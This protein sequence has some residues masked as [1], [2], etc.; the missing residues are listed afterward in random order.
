VHRALG[1]HERAVNADPAHPLMRELDL[2]YPL[3]V[4]RLEAGEWSSSVP[5]RAL[6]EGRLGV[7]VGEPLDDAAAGLRAALA[8]LP[9]ELRFDGARFASG[10]TPPDHPFTRLVLESFPG[11]RPVGVPYGADMRLFCERGIPCVMAGTAGL[12]LAHAVDERVAVADLVRLA[13]GLRRV[14]EHFPPSFG[15]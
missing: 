3:S 8:D 13:E 6:F 14:I 12:E 5:D 2:P 7:R 11:S 9:V 4:G 15:T 1:E 10:E